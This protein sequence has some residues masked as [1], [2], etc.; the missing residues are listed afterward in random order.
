MRLPRSAWLTFAS[1]MRMPNIFRSKRV[2]VARHARDTTLVVSSRTAWPELNAFGQRMAWN[3]PFYSS[4]GSDFTCD[5]HVTLDSRVAPLE[6][7]YRDEAELQQY[8]EDVEGE[9]HGVS[10]FLRDGNSIFHTYS[11]YARGTDI[12][13]GTLNYL[14]LTPLGRQEEW[15]EPPGRANS[16]A[17]GWWCLHDE[18]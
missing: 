17:G 3:V 6:Y 14:D 1:R 2:Q 16:S 11:T 18:Y 4:H 9:A 15:E 5:F 13:N 7:N 12:L 8:A 10:V